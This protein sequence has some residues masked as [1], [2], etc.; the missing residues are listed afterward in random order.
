[1]RSRRLLTYLH[2]GALWLQIIASFLAVVFGGLQRANIEDVRKKLEAFEGLV[3]FVE[4]SHANAWWLLPCAVL[5][6]GLLGLLRKYAGAPWIWDII[7]FQLD[8]IRQIAFTVDTE[9]G[10]HFHRVTLFKKKRWAWCCRKWPWQGWLVA[11]ER[12]GHT[13]R[14]RAI[15]FKAPD[16]ADFAEGVAG[17]TWARDQ[18]VRISNLP[19]LGEQASDG[20]L[21][22][23]A[24][25]TGLTIES[26]RE[27]RPRARSLTGIP[28]E[29]RGRLWGV[30]VL[31]SRRPDAIMQD[32]EATYREAS[33][34]LG[35]LLEKL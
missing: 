11:V 25:K 26:V 33:K 22:V 21:R 23:Y 19:P 27:T 4:W 18:I 32:G 12:S 17:M 34:L 5:I 14:T 31:D 16:N 20:D 29:V 1:M 30:L 3:A 15:R 8:S 9:D 24:D 10:H 13:T 2:T 35:K 7:K 28:V 6:A